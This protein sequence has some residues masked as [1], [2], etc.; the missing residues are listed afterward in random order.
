MKKIFAFFKEAWHRFGLPSPTFFQVIQWA[1]AGVTF[2]TGLPGILLQY[3]GKLGIT[4]PDWVFTL[5]NRAVAWAAIVGLIISKLVVKNPDATKTKDG[6][7]K[8]LLPF[9]KNN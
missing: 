7:E 6:V 1:S 8:P 5:S 3:Q 2:V 4:F 9:T